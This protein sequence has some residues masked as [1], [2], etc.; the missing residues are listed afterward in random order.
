LQNEWKELVEKECDAL[1]PGL[2]EIVCIIRSIVALK[3]SILKK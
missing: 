2:S 1:G 3:F